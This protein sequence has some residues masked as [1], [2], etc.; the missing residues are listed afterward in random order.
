METV[1]A[2]ELLGIYRAAYDER[3]EAI[4]VLEAKLSELKAPLEELER[5]IK[6]KVVS[7]GESVEYLGVRAT[8]TKAHTRYSWSNDK[9]EGFAMA[10][11]EILAARKESRVKARA[12][13]KVVG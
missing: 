8:Y 12:S 10:H 2:L 3:K 6:D 5:A 1:T 9:L 7:D 13:L 11:P 4:A